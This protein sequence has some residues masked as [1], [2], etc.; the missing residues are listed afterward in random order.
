MWESL[1]NVRD[2]EKPFLD[3]HISLDIGEVT[4]TRVLIIARNMG[5]SSEISH[6]KSHTQTPLGN[7]KPL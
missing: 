3:A 7:A 6:F 1:M 4:L 5:R 2:V